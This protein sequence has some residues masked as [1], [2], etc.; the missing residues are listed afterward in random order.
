M[1]SRKRTII[2]DEAVRLHTATGDY[3]GTLNIQGNL[4]L[5]SQDSRENLEAIIAMANVALT[6]ALLA[7]FSGLCML[8]SPQLRLSM[9]LD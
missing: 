7:A 8:L 4:L 5:P 9:R 6:P 2:S 1:T 3:A